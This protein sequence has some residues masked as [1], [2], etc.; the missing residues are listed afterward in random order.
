MKYVLKNLKQFVTK[1]RLVFVLFIFCQIVS[2]LILLLSY[3]VYM[4]YKEN[5]DQEFLSTAGLYGDGYIGEE[6][7]NLKKMSLSICFL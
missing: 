2:I 3:G 7:K 4:N 6:E 5:Y 1:N